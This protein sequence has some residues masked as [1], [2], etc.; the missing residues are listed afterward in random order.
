MRKLIG[1][2]IIPAAVV[3]L[4]GCETFSGKNSKYERQVRNLNART[5]ESSRIYEDQLQKISARLV[6]IQERQ[7]ETAAKVNQLQNY[8]ST[9]SRQNASLQNQVNALKNDLNAESKSRQE[10]INKMADQLAGELGK[11]VNTMRR[12]RRSS[13]GGGPS[14]S[15][16]FYEYTVQSGATLSAIAK[17]YKVSVEDIKQANGLKN[18][19]IRVGQ[20]LYIPKK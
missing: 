18:N 7:N 20:K 2:L 16:K 19:M 4:T 15:G 13:S 8:I 5:A 9:M 14:G 6:E 10:S 3:V 12:T 1:F 17:A 11:A